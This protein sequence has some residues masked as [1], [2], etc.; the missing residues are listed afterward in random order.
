[1]F[2]F[3]GGSCRCPSSW[4]LQMFCH[5]GTPD[6]RFLRYIPDRWASIHSTGEPLA[7]CLP[8][9]ATYRC[10]QVFLSFEL[11]SVQ[12]FLIQVYFL[13]LTGMLLNRNP[14]RN[15]L[16]SPPPRCF[17]VKH[18]PTWICFRI[19]EPHAGVL[20]CRCSHTGIAN[21]FPHRNSLFECCSFHR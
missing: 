21:T 2:L 14:P 7:C 8:R 10:S 4:G 6:R 19:T 12:M 17:R 1:M 15:A 9:C 5:R 16:Y 13:H 20:R 11:N 18:T 3:T